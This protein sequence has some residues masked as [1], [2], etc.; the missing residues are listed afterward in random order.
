[1]QPRATLNSWSSSFYFLS[2]MG[3]MGMVLHKAEDQTH[4]SVAF[5]EQS[6]KPSPLNLLSAC[7]LATV[8]WLS[9][10][11]NYK[12]LQ[13]KE[14]IQSVLPFGRGSRTWL[15]LQNWDFNGLRREHHVI[16]TLLGMEPVETSK[17]ERLWCGSL[18]ARYSA[19]RCSY[20]FHECGLE[21]LTAHLE[22][23]FMVRRAGGNVGL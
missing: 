3:C 6:Y 1:M 4:V 13:D 15:W 5:H 2:I 8:L 19:K 22:Q 14:S 16:G 21:N 9:D 7:L 11:I 10:A 18:G 23:T 17:V 12:V 20:P